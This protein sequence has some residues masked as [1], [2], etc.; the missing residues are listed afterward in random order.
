M[1][2]QKKGH[3]VLCGFDGLGQRTL[4]ELVKLGEE[5]TVVADNA[6]ESA[7]ELARSMGAAYLKGNY[8]DE[9]VLRDACV[10][11]AHALVI[12][13]DDDVGNIHAALAAQ[14]LNPN[15]K[16]VL[17]IF[18]QDFGHRL[19][20]LFNNCEVLSSSA[21][22][23]PAFV[24]AAL[25]QDWEQEISLAGHTL[26]VRRSSTTNPEA[27]AALAR[28]SETG[29]VEL[30]PKGY[31]DDLLCLVEP[32]VLRRLAPRM[33]ARTNVWSKLA[34]YVK[35][36]ARSADRRLAYALLFLFG[37]GV[38]AMLIFF[39]TNNLDLVDAFYNTTTI[40]ISGGL[41]DLD[42]LATPLPLKLFGTLLMI[43]GAT[44][45]T[46][47]YALVTDAV[48]SVRLDKALGRSDVTLR[49]HVVV[50]GLG[51]IGYRVVDQLHELGVPVAAA[52]KNEDAWGI[53]DI[54]RSG[55]P[56]IHADARAPETLRALNV[57]HARSIVVATDDDAANLETALNARAIKSDL[58][59]VLRLYDTDL[60]A[61][62][63][64]AFDIHISRSVSALAAPRFAAAAVAERVAATIPVKHRVVIVAQSTVEPTSRAN[65][66]TVGALESDFE[67]RVVMVDRNGKQT[68]QPPPTLQLKAGD[69]LAIVATRKGL[70]RVLEMTKGE[71]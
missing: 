25:R 21:I 28:V 62:V 26:R 44:T 4:D 51:N 36:L 9:S 11:D 70:V 17:R 20:A 16:I 31:D 38:L 23:A 35:A 50:C 55:V 71:G 5:V 53:P 58:R 61:R 32:R 64:R 37:L 15:I 49:D 3:V 30:F 29:A 13:A 57:E 47:F 14:E 8:R 67:G 46:V 27:V 22:A 24:S 59:V 41:G 12:T 60:A 66:K 39:M 52:E 65:G 43:I 10:R 34:S 40:I 48:V 63:E 18:N 7:I 69:D 1:P 54:R 19:Q 45:L 68:W 33:R 56:V 2:Y 42:P 6:A